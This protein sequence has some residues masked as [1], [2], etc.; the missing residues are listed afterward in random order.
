[1]VECVGANEPAL[2]TKVI[3][4]TRCS[5]HEE[6]FNHSITMWMILV[7]FTML[8]IL[9]LG[10]K[11][12][13]S[14]AISIRTSILSDRVFFFQKGVCPMMYTINLIRYPSKT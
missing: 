6:E 14:I 3:L 12:P 1:M 5:F 11:A 13:A 9:P 8:T 10:Y 7:E 4:T 2:P